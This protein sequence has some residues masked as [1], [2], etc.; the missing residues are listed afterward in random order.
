PDP[1]PRPPKGI[2][3]IRATESP[4]DRKPT[5]Q[6]GASGPMDHGPPRR[7]ASCGPGARPLSGLRRRIPVEA[8][9]TRTLRIAP[10]R[11]RWPRPGASMSPANTL[12]IK[13]VLIDSLH[14]DPANARLHPETNL[15]AITAS[16]RR[17]GQA[18]PLVVQAGTGRVIAG[19]GRLIA[20]K[21]L[22]WTEAD[23][24]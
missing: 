2:C 13:R 3:P 9:P 19:N 12:A 20:M 17:F 8:P 22:G 10:N 5:Y 11:P 21:K 23:I 4:S 7:F 24:V 14:L 18:E 1:L 15:D 16:L 6:R